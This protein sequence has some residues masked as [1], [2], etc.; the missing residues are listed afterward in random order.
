MIELHESAF[1]LMEIQNMKE[2]T[3]P[4]VPGAGEFE[5]HRVLARALRCQIT[6][7]LILVLLVV[8]YRGGAFD[9]MVRPEDPPELVLIAKLSVWV[10][11]GFMALMLGFYSI[12]YFIASGRSA[13][14]AR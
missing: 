1:T 12:V 8:L 11:M 5:R 3:T 13:G 6:T 9:S 2:T 10:F 7:G 4:H 14:G